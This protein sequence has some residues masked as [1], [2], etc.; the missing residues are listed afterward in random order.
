MTN[1]KFSFAFEIGHK[2]PLSLFPNHILPREIFSHATRYIPKRKYMLS[3]HTNLPSTQ[4]KCFL[5]RNEYV[6]LNF[7]HQHTLFVLF[8][9]SHTHAIYVFVCYIIF[10]SL[11]SLPPA[12][13][14]AA[15]QC[16]ACRALYH[17]EKLFYM[18]FK[19]V[20]IQII[21]ILR[22]ILNR[23]YDIRSR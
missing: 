10:V 14:A 19:C 5:V 18:R 12:I 3:A 2:L 8:S 15:V 17:F 22:N 21:S 6:D 16:I 11:T 9:N 23:I 13:L 1:F 20:S 4:K 7:R